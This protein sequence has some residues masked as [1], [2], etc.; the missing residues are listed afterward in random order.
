MAESVDA[1]DSKSAAARCEGSSPSLGTTGI[2][3]PSLL[4]VAGQIQANSSHPTRSVS[5]A[6]SGQ[7]TMRASGPTGPTPLA[8]GCGKV[9][10][11]R[12]RARP[13]VLFGQIPISVVLLS[14][15]SH[16]AGVALC[17]HLA[18]TFLTAPG[19]SESPG[20][21]MPGR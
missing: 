21:A 3:A 4:A 10:C 7:Y 14:S 16:L 15:A 9:P 1:A 5:S 20:R 11:D 17:A 12:F 6:E 19:V 18:Y 13:R 2:L 8:L